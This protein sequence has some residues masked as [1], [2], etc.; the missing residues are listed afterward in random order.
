MTGG[1]SVSVETLI[2]QLAVSAADGDLE[3]I[4]LLGG[5]PFSQ[6]AGC[7]RLATAAHELELSVMTFSGFTLAELRARD[8]SDVRA[9]LDETD[10][11]VDG[12]YD[13]SQPDTQRRWIGSRNQQI[14]FLS[15]RCDQADP[16][17]GEPNTLELRIVDGELSVNGFPAAKVRTLWKRPDRRHR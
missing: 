15:D 17:W 2:G 1:H 11:L 5:E 9:L 4:T 3:G 16:R 6:P 14:H 13:Q 7:A 8:D 12:P 10:I